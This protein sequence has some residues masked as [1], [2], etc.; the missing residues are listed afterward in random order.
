MRYL[1]SFLV[2]HS[3][4]KVLLS[5]T[6]PVH[7]TSRLVRLSGLCRK[8][9]TAAWRSWLLMF[10]E[11]SCLRGQILKASP[12]DMSSMGTVLE[13][14]LQ[15]AESRA[16]NGR[17]KSAADLSDLCWAPRECSR[18]AGWQIAFRACPSADILSDFG[19]LKLSS[20]L[21]LYEHG[22]TAC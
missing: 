11:E 1:I 22:L 14:L 4:L 5:C 9:A 2:T 18:L 17:R 3:S 7:H 19:K 20:C 12:A 13:S 21:S 10:L 15:R 16:P 6:S 8:S